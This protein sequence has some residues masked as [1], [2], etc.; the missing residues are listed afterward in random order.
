VTFAERIALGP[1]LITMFLSLPR[2][3]G[4][5]PTYFK[6]EMLTKMHP[7]SN[8]VKSIVI[9]VKYMP[10]QVVFSDELIVWDF[11]IEKKTDPPI[12]AKIKKKPKENAILSQGDIL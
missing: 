10:N 8:T 11:I 3:V 2:A 1:Y 12:I 4:C 7:N 6:R 5:D 9:R